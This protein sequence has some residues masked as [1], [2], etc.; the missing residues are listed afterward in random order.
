M[1][2]FLIL[3]VLLFC[4][5]STK[6][7]EQSIDSLK[8]ELNELSDDKDKLSCLINISSNYLIY[9]L[10]SALHYGRIAYN[11]TDEIGDSSLINKSIF[12]LAK[13]FHHRAEY[14]NALSYYKKNLEYY[15]STRQDSNL[16]SVLGNMGLIYQNRN[17]LDKALELYKESLN[18]DRLYG[19]KS[20]IIYNLTDIGY[21]YFLKSE[22]VIAQEYYNEGLKIIEGGEK[23]IEFTSLAASLN[24][25]IAQIFYTVLDNNNAL[26]YYFKAIEI[27]KSIN[28]EYYLSSIYHNISLIYATLN[29][30]DKSMEYLEKTKELES[31]TNDYYRLFTTEMAISTLYLKKNNSKKAIEII[32]DVIKKN[33]V[34]KFELI[35]AKAYSNK[36]NINVF[37]EDLNEA[38]KN[39]NIARDLYKKR[40]DKLNIESINAELGKLFIL[41]SDKDKLKNVEVFEYGISRNPKSNLKKGIEILNDVLKSDE[42]KSNK[43]FFEDI[44]LDLS[45]AYEKIGDSDKALETYKIYMEYLKDSYNEEKL[46]EFGRIEA[47]HAILLENMRNERELK[48]SLAEKRSMDRRRNTLQYL[49]IAFFIIGFLLLIIFSSRFKMSEWVAKALVFITFIF[50]FEFISVVFDPMTDRWSGGEP[51]LKFV[52]NLSL[53]L[54]IYPVHK[55]LEKRAKSQVIKPQIKK[56]NEIMVDFKSKHEA[57]ETEEENK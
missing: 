6:A 22:Y 32:D 25:K 55:I 33:K 36:A 38:F 39:Y 8:K 31:R 28:Q 52:M 46:I 17:N 43:S 14:D 49:G 53:A 15:R 26:K 1:K 37:D 7:A 24:D 56:I 42:A 34:Y 3:T 29:D 47:K 41:L 30:I 48:Q 21:L 51:L 11:K 50:L 16:S 13:V 27:Y 5:Y 35:D 23:T 19:N 40:N 44:F 2:L 4:I 18:L 12:N 45:K 54:V 9:N 20:G 57:G 10:D